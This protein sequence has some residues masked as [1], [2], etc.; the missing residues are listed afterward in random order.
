MSTYFG[1]VEREADNYINW[2]DVSR[3]LTTTFND[4]NRVREEKKQALDDDFRAELK[5]LTLQPKGKSE[6]A[7]KFITEYGDNASNF[8]LMQN[9]LLKAGKSKLKD[10]IYAKQN[11]TDGTENLFKIMK[12]YQ[13]NYS[14]NM[15]RYE[16]EI[17]SSAE[18]WLLGQVEKFADFSKSGAYIAGDGSVS[19]AMKTMKNVDGQEIYTL[20]TK[21][22]E[23]ASLSVL[24]DVVNTKINRYKANDVTTKLAKE[25]GIQVESLYVNGVIQ[26]VKDIT[27]REYGKDVFQS[28]ETLRNAIS[29]I[30]SNERKGLVLRTNE[31]TKVSDTAEGNETEVA[32]IYL[33]AKKKDA[34][35]LTDIDKKVINFVETKLKDEIAEASGP[36]FKFYEAETDIIRAAIST[37]E[38]Y[39]SILADNK[40]IASNG[41]AYDFKAVNSKE[42]AEQIVKENPNLICML[43]NKPVLTDSQEGEAI[44][45]MRELMRAKYTLEEVA[46]GS[47]SKVDVGMSAPPKAQLTEE[48]K[49]RDAKFQE[50]AQEANFLA[51][52]HSGNK[53]SIETA[54]QHYINRSN[55]T[56]VGFIRDPRKITVKYND[57]TTAEMRLYDTDNKPISLHEFIIENAGLFH[58][59]EDFNFNQVLS[60]FNNTLLPNISSEV[61]T[62]SVTSGFTNA[63]GFRS[64]EQKSQEELVNELQ[65]GKYGVMQLTGTKG[66]SLNADTRKK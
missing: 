11:V 43:G 46:K 66:N 44:E 32:Q 35:K 1:Y 40:K 60:R 52:M 23:V 51:Q 64:S 41:K 34:D 16:K 48:D 9:R 38:N 55:G 30:D 31:K 65:P 18:P 56:I 26:S 33:D 22:G 50:T 54:M 6:E 13:A 24:S 59:A 36:K 3:D 10:Y 62:Q 37:P 25:M 28:I 27:K 14:E 63:A 57:G 29:D 5:K 58:K 20:D 61:L 8:L 45:F 12:D 21:P 47:T 53:R 49:K 7:N 2:A 42:E 19:V 4:I 17:S 39:M 15:E